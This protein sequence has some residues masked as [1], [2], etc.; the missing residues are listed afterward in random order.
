MLF[1]LGL[2]ASRHVCLL[3]RGA[4]KEHFIERNNRIVNGSA[5]TFY[6]MHCANRW[7]TVSVLCEHLTRL[8]TLQVTTEE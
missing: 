2:F 8:W 3:A 7:V 5:S 4:S 1:V 6:H